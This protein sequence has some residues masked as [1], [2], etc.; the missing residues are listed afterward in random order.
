MERRVFQLVPITRIEVG[1][2]V[3]NLLWGRSCFNTAS[4]IEVRMEGYYGQHGAKNRLHSS[5]WYAAPGCL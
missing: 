2:R 3:E 5:H 1:H 4:S